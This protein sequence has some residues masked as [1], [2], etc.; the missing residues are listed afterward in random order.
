MLAQE[1]ISDI[2][3]ALRTSDT[4]INALNWMEVFR[5]SH[6]PIVANGKYLGLI[7]DSDI[8]DLNTPAEA[9]G[10]YELSLLDVYIKNNQH[11]YDAISIILDYRLT[12]VPVVN[13][14][15]KYLG[16]ITLPEL[17]KSFS[18]IAGLEQPGGIVVLE[19]NPKKYSLAEIA[20]IVESNNARILSSYVSS[21]DANTNVLVTLK[22]NT[23]ELSFI[24]RTFE[25]YDY[26]IKHS[27]ESDQI[28]EAF[29][30]DRYEAFL[31]Y[32]SV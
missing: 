23:S 21:E 8:Y 16:L 27:F 19:I 17:V 30:K 18:I 12:V 2:I 10:S 25:R 3:P 11:I 20:Q 32:L 31:N 6:L 13:D 14:N 28:N 29:A 4:G 15:K 5:V 26:M 7:C 24:L 22:I 9:I 1:I